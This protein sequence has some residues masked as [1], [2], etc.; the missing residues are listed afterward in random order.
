MSYSVD[1]QK[2]TLKIILSN[3]SNNNDFDSLNNEI[4]S[5]ESVK[6]IFLDLKDC[7]YIQSK[8][9]SN[10]IGLKKL[11]SSIGCDFILT[12]VQES[13]YQIFELT[14]LLSIFRI[15]RDFSSYS[16]SELIEFF[17]DQEI[18]DRVSEHIAM[19]YDDQLKEVLYS[20]LDTDDYL[21]KEYAVLSIGRAHDTDALDKIREV[22]QE[23]VPNTSRACVLVLGWF[24]D[25][26][27][28]TEIYNLLNSD[29]GSLA[30]AA[31]ASIALLSDDSDPLKLEKMIDKA[32][33]E[34]RG[35]IYRVL[36][37]INDSY[38]L[39][40]LTRQL[41]VE[42]DDE[43]LKAILIKY[44][45]FFNKPLV[46]DLLLEKLDDTSLKVRESAAA[47]LIRIKATDKIDAILEKVSNEDSWVGYFATKAI[48]E[49]THS[50]KITELLIG[51]YLSVAENVKLAIIEALGKM[52]NDC[53]DFLYQL[54]SD[55]N[56]DIRKEVLSS[57]MLINKNLAA[58]ASVEILN[59]EASWI[60]RF[61]AVE[62]IGIVKPEGF[63]SILEKTMDKE[64]NKYVKDKISVLLDSV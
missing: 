55:E 36:S 39:S 7:E 27:S 9:I 51:K 41:E 32:S 63:I 64:S 44:I 61:K 19:H 60:V 6:Q 26:E 53:S 37:L 29:D 50:E 58:S 20:L 38:S 24:G 35:T 30:E 47:S 42:E 59:D 40:I 2:G 48:G 15:E 4:K 18:A 17:Q 54:T 22:L 3:D 33:S 52:G 21:M 1:I 10:I 49:L 16:P 56:E 57:L 34:L 43:N 28:K 46:A 62:I 31:A 23:N 14:N 25:I 11:A 8:A 5:H 13:V 12:N 45:S